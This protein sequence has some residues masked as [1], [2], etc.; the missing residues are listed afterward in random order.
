MEHCTSC[1]DGIC[2]VVANIVCSEMREAYTNKLFL[3][4]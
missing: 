1:V 2:I 3:L 4:K